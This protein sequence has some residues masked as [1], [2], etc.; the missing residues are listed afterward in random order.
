MDDLSPI[1]H[2]PGAADRQ[3][4]TSRAE[5]GVQTEAALGWG[6]ANKRSEQTEL[7]KLGFVRLTSAKSLLFGTCSQAAEPTLQRFLGGAMVCAASIA[8]GTMRLGV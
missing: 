1:P 3:T 6:A 7:H 5:D 8:Q 2:S 4:D